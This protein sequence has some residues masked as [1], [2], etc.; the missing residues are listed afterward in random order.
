MRTTREARDVIEAAPTH[1]RRFITRLRKSAIVTVA[2]LSLVG[3]SIGSASA[4]TSDQSVATPPS[5]L[6]SAASSVHVFTAAEMSAYPTVIYGTQYAGEAWKALTPQ[7]RANLFNKLSDLS[8]AIVNA[9]NDLGAVANAGPGGMR[10]NWNITVG[11]YIYFNNMSPSDQ[12]WFLM[13]GTA[14]IAGTICAISAGTAC[15][16][17]GTLASAVISGIGEYAHPTCWVTMAFTYSGNLVPSQYR[18][19]HC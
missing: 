15:W 7:E 1:S 18:I 2:A 19:L 14:T 16:V 9:N 13:A 6:T 3:S 12:R 8:R 17:A 10:A 11:R 4:A 5:I